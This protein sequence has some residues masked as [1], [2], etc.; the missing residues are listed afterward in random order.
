MFKKHFRIMFVSNNKLI[1]QRRRFWIFWFTLTEFRGY[2]A[3]DSER[4]IEFST[5][6]NAMKYIENMYNVPKPIFVRKVII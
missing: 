2:E 1:I 6:A 3:S 4:P 5:L